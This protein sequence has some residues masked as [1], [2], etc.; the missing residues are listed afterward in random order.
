MSLEANT[1]A[2]NMRNSGARSR[3]CQLHMH[4]KGRTKVQELQGLGCPKL[5]VHLKAASFQVGCVGG[6]AVLQQALAHIIPASLSCLPCK[7]QGAV[8]DTEW[9]CAASPMA[10]SCQQEAVVLAQKPPTAVKRWMRPPRGRADLL[11]HT[12][13]PLQLS[14]GTVLLVD[15][16]PMGEGRLSETGLSSFQALNTL[17]QEQ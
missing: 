2:A 16:T 11:L 15:E 14:N 5:K 6:M 10:P 13:S 4:V 7:L 12:R 17:I 3:D 1:S 9:H 8:P